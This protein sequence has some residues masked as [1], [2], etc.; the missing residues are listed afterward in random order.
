MGRVKTRKVRNI[1][2]NNLNDSLDDKVKKEAID[3]DI[4]FV[5][6]RENA[7][8]YAKSVESTDKLN[9]KIE[10]ED[11]LSIGVM[12]L[13]LVLCL[14]V[15]IVLGY[16]LYRLAINSSAVVLIFNPFR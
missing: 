9:K 10:A 1:K 14:V 7:H 3:D 5:V 16:L 11:S 15:G 4:D 6:E 8:N 13:I 2:R 12:V